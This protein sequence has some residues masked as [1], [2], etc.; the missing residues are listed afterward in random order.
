MVCLWHAAVADAQK[1]A[2]LADKLA[3]RFSTKPENV[4]AAVVKQG[5][6]LAAAKR[7]L[8]MRTEALL[9]YRA[10]GLMQSAEPVCGTKLVVHAEDGLNAQ[11][12]KSFA[13]K[14]C[15][16][17]RVVAVLFSHVGD[18]VYYQLSRAAGVPFS[19]REAC[20]ALNAM[21]G[22]KRRGTGRCGTGQRKGTN[23]L[24]GTACT[25]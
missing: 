23:G 16:E 12:L 17:E 19:M 9:A 10:A 3:R 20:A 1:N 22:G 6:D 18:T 5:D 15:G 7:E 2:L 13:E 4:L 8:R 14:L 25:V 24:C 21:T 11:E